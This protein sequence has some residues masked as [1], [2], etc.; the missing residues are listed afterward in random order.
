MERW[1]SRT[2]VPRTGHRQPVWQAW[3]LQLDTGVWVCV[4]VRVPTAKHE[5]PLGIQHRPPY[6]VIGNPA[7]ATIRSYWESSTGHRTALLGIQH[8]PPYSVIGNP[9]QATVQRYWESSTG[10]RT[11]LLGIQHRPPYSYSRQ[12]WLDAYSVTSI[13]IATNNDNAV[14]VQCLHPKPFILG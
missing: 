1:L 11:A 7:Q 9:A 14:T 12:R 8:R 6:S 3:D 4:G 13:S 2:S 10:H 5:F